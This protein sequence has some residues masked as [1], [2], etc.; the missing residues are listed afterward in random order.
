M[1]VRGWALSQ[2][3]VFIV[4]PI[5]GGVIAG[6]VYRAFFETGELPA[7]IPTAGAPRESEI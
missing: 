4:F 2:I 6:L 3:W 5:V 1:F 7:D